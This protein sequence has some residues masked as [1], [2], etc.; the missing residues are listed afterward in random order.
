MITEKEM[1]FN[2]KEIEDFI[3]Q[4]YAENF[5]LMRLETGAAISPEVKQAGLE[6]VLIYWRVMREIALNVT[7]T[8]VRLSLPQLESPH[9]RE[10]GIEGVVDILRDA[11]RTLMYDIKTHDADYVQAHLDLYEDQLNVYAHIWE[12]L[13]KQKL[14]GTAVICT[15][16]PARVREALQRDDAVALDR[17]LQAW[18]P[19]IEIAFNKRR[20]EETIRAFGRVVDAIEERDFKPPPL[21]KLNARYTPDKPVRF[22]TNVCRNCDA[23]FSCGAYRAYARRGRGQVERNFARFIAD[24]ESEENL[25]QWRIAAIEAVE[26]SEL[27]F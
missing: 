19:L 20:V 18:Q 8:E 21:E 2:E 22:A 6:Q 5:E 16:L 9:E 26:Q 14:D 13:H 11:D 15:R 17:A 3:R 1:P 27:P 25:E 12:H 7:D 10:F 23:R 4:R 24:L